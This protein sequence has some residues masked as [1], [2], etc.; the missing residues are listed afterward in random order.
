MKYFTLLILNTTILGNIQAGSI[1]GGEISYSR[2]SVNPLRIHLSVNLYSPRH[3]LQDSILISWG[4]TS[5]YSQIQSSN[6]VGNSIYKNTYKAIHTYSTIPIGG[7]YSISTINNNRIDGI[8]NID[9]GNSINTPFY[10]EAKINLQHQSVLF[11][12]QSPFFDSLP[13]FY[14]YKSLPYEINPNLVDLDGDSLVVESI[15]PLQDENVNVPAYSFPEQYCIAN[16]AQSN[17]F[18]INSYTGEII[19]NVPCRIGIYSIAMRISEFRNGNLLGSIMRDQNIYVLANPNSIL[20]LSAD[21]LTVSPNPV[22]TT[23]TCS[24]TD[25]TTIPTLQVFSIEGKAITETIPATQTKTEI[26]VSH[27]PAGLYFL[28]V[29]DEKQ[30]AVRRFVKQ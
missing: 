26:D 24:L 13:V 22:T 30:R 10:I 16:G 3:L 28:V 11:N 19:W 1:W 14:S 25:L 29:Q 18:N 7:T 17:T 23:L 27:L 8:N 21:D 9:G 2:D 15:I 12:N 5:I 6:F 20:Q 4:D